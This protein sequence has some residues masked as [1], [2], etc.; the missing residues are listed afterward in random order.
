VQER[1]RVVGD[2]F[3]E[4]LRVPF[5]SGGSQRPGSL[6]LWATR[7]LSG[8]A[9]YAAEPGSLAIN[10]CFSP[11]GVLALGATAGS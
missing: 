1:N 5:L 10:A 4:P 3:L 7:M 8:P 9:A 6:V 11:T 2:E